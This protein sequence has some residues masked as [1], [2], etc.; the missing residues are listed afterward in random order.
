MIP[1]YYED[2]N[3]PLIHIINISTSLTMEQY[4]L[5]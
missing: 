3:S 2:I 5:S 4:L 1:D